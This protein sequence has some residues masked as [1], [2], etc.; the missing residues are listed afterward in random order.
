MKVKHTSILGPNACVLVA[1]KN[2]CSWLDEQHIRDVGL[3]NKFYSPRG[4]TISGEIPKY[5]DHLG[6]Q[7]KDVPLPPINEPKL[8]IHRFS[9]KHSLG[10]FLILVNGHALLLN[11][12]RVFDPNL[13]NYGI[14]R[15]VNQAFEILNSDMEPEDLTWTQETKFVLRVNSPRGGLG[16]RKG[17]ESEKTFWV[18]KQHPEGISFDEAKHFY[19]TKIET[20]VYFIERAIITKKG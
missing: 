2:A 17:S 6:I 8:T 19:H 4:G 1:F 18:L 20:W 5:M 10:V 16:F 11:N 13:T 15:K 3:V 9:K 12:G 14:Q 7:Y